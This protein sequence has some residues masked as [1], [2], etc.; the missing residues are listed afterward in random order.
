[1]ARL[2]SPGMWVFVGPPL[3]ANPPSCGSVLVRSMPGR[4][5]QAPGGRVVG[6]QVVAGRAGRAAVVHNAAVR[7]AV[8]DA[9]P[10]QEF[11]R[12][13]IWSSEV[14]DTPSRCSSVPAECA[15]AD[16]QDPGVGDGAAAARGLDAPT[17]AGQPRV[18]AE[19][20]RSSTPLRPPTNIP[21]PR[22]ARSVSRVAPVKVSPPSE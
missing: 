17:T 4:A 10:D 13:P 11:G 14:V 22:M 7:A 1:M 8:K 9:V 20:R 5:R 6:E 12:R 21:A 18:A 15:E 2:N 16:L 3:S 19:R